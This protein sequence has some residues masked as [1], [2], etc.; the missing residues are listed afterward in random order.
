MAADLE[1]ST[2]SDAGAPLPKLAITIGASGAARNGALGRTSRPAG[3]ESVAPA[4]NKTES[5]GAKVRAF[6]FAAVRHGEAGEVPELESE[7]EGLMKK[8]SDEAQRICT[9]TEIFRRSRAW[10]IDGRVAR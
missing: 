6:A 1:P 5:P 3:S 10:L 9:K 2:T 4:S 7:P 8:V